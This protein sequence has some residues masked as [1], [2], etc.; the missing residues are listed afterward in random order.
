M[1]IT[2]AEYQRALELSR[3]SGVKD[4]DSADLWQVCRCYR[5]QIFDREAAERGLKLLRKS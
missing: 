5:G 2:E 4:Q 3:T 1:K